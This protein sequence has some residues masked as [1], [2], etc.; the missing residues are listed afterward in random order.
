[1]RKS[2]FNSFKNEKIILSRGTKCFEA[3]K[4]RY[5]RFKAGHP[6][7][8]LEAL[9]NYYTDISQSYINYKKRKNHKTNFTFS[10]KDLFKSIKLFY[11]AYQSHFEK[12]MDQ[13]VN[14]GPFAK[15]HLFFFTLFKVNL[16][17]F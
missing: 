1:M 6:A 12:K 5:N 7:G 17:N 10:T 2:D 11:M 16:K 8:F 15:Y 9:A 13:T 4:L 3:N 14:L